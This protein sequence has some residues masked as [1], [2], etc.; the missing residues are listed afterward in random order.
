M[1]AFDRRAHAISLFARE[2][3][4]DT[5]LLVTKNSGEELS[6][7]CRRHRRHYAELFLPGE[8]GVEEF[9]QRHPEAPLEQVG[10]ARNCVC[11]GSVRA[12]QI[13]FGAGESP[14]HAITVRTEL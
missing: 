13:D 7:F 4:S 10:D 6:A 12:I 11:N 2:I 14:A 1:H 9:R 3:L 5:Q 8:V